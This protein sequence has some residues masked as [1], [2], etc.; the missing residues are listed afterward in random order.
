MIGCF[1]RRHVM[2]QTGFLAGVLV[3]LL[4]FAGAVAAGA[5]DEQA[6]RD[7]RPER[8]IGIYTDFSGVVIPLGESDHPESAH[9]DDQAGKLFSKS[10]AKS[11]YFL[12]R[13]EL[14]K[15]VSA[16]KELAF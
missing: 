4:V 3:A 14:E 6:K 8:G 1:G 2:Q 16:K 11:T 5:A 12:N 13:K 10:L 15:H 7:D 9:F